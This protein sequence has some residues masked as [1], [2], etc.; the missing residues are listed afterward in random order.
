MPSKL[1][2]WLC[3]KVKAEV[4]EIIGNEV[5]LEVEPLKT[6]GCSILRRMQ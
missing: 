5:V 6:I 3:M 1:L 4:E 2:K